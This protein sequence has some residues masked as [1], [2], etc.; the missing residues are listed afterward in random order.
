MFKH[1]YL[2]NVVLIHRDSTAIQMKKVMR[3]IRS[4][5]VFD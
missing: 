4:I 3:N 5:I 2:I 1:Q